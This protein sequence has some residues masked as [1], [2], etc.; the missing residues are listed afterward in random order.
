MSCLGLEL[1]EAC[2]PAWIQFPVVYRFEN[3]ATRF[4]IVSAIPKTTALGKI[5]NVRKNLPE[6]LVNH[7]DPELSDAR[8]VKEKCPTWNP[9]Q[10]PAGFRVAP[11]PVTWADFPDRSESLFRK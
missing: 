2:E 4:S 5:L 3:R 11:F 6:T 7:P 8:C 10:L 9:E 1:S